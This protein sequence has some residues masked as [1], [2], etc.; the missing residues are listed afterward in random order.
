MRDSGLCDW[1][2]FFLLALTLALSGGAWADGAI[3]LS[4][5]VTE[6]DAWPAARIWVDEGGQ[7]RL[8]EVLAQPERFIRPA[9][10][11]ANLGREHRPTW[12]LLRLAARGG[13]STWIVELG[14]ASLAEI[15]AYL[16]RD[17]AVLKHQ[18]LGRTVAMAQRPLPSR[19]NAFPITLDEPGDYALVLRVQTDSSLLLPLQIWA[20]QAFWAAEARRQ[21]L[22]GLAL[23]TSLILLALSLIQWLM[24]RAPM[25]LF[26]AGLVAGMAMF[27]V[28]MSGLGRQY[29]WPNWPGGA[30][31]M[32]PQAVLFAAAVGSLFCRDALRLAERRPRHAR[33][34]SWTSAAIFGGLALSLAGVLDYAQAS[35]LSTIASVV[36]TLIAL[37]PAW[38]FARQGDRPARLLLS[39]WSIYTVGSVVTTGVLIG[40]LPVNLFTL[41]ALSASTFVAALLWLQVLSLRTLEFRRQAVLAEA[42]QTRLHALAH[43]DLLTGAPNRRGLEARLSVLLPPG[44]RPTELCLYLIDLDGFKAVNDG[45]GHDAGDELL[46]QVVLRLQEQLRGGDVVARLGGDEFVVL[47]PSVHDDAQAQRLGH[48]L[49]AAFSQPFDLGGPQSARVGL[50]MGY[51]LAPEDGADSA[52]LMQRADAAMYEGKRAGKNCL[53]RGRATPEPDIA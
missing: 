8:A 25:F 48:K 18:T 10:P 26:N 3:H 41:T 37:G 1:L 40:R 35:A 29:L 33:A 24:Q 36:P 34:L 52:T 38:R 42:E 13:P 50:T 30:P 16:V 45:L 39:A 12:I 22:F 5:D 31:S 46:R 17:G 32:A 27:F 21:L 20:P 11:R 23:G 28:S 44:R 9:V 15:D 49:L 2:R 43:T 14:H 51:V 53:R 4:A 6:V 7:T 19:T 47:A